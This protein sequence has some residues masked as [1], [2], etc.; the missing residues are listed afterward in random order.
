[1]DIMIKNQ[2]DT[3]NQQIKNLNSPY[4]GDTKDCSETIILTACAE[5]KEQSCLIDKY[6][7]NTPLRFKRVVEFFRMTG[8]SMLCGESLPRRSYRRTQKQLP[9]YVS[10]G[11]GEK[12][13]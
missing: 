9:R 3:I 4:H 8:I 6:V 12:K 2:I 1:M 10:R 5:I 7:E 13:E 11:I